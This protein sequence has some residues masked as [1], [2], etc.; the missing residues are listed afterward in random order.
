M[1]M[2]NCE[3]VNRLEPGAY[4]NG[5]APMKEGAIMNASLG[6]PSRRDLI[7]FLGAGLTSLMLPTRGEALSPNPILTRNEAVTLY[8]ST[9]GDTNLTKLVPEAEIYEALNRMLMEALR[10]PLSGIEVIYAP[11]GKSKSE[12][13]SR[14][15]KRPLM[16]TVYLTVRAW[17]LDDPTFEGLVGAVSVFFHKNV[18]DRGTGQSRTYYIDFIP[19]PLVAPLEAEAIRD[20]VFQAVMKILND[21]IPDLVALNPAD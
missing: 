18:L 15:N 11:Y 1:D 5:G 10:Y 6:H 2:R 9:E 13:I 4:G 16:I 20:R 14:L 12:A 7:T 19:E 3:I 17:D 8:F 21:I